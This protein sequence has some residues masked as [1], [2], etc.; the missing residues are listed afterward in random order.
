MST[1]PLL[2]ISENC[3][4]PRCSSVSERLNKLWYIH[5]M[6]YYSSIKRN[7]LLIHATTWISLQRI[8]LSE[9]KILKGCILYY[10]I[11]LYNTDVRQALTSSVTTKS[12]TRDPCGDENILHLD[13]INVS[14]LVVILYY[15]F[16]RCFHWGKLGKGYT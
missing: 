3:K 6:D 11:H 9:K 2:R 16:A 8:M 14:I 12:N 7:E 5:T 10:S 13:C 4:Q 15:S 1:V